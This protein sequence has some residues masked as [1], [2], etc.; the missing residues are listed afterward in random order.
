[1]PPKGRSAEREDDFASPALPGSGAQH[2]GPGS[3]GVSPRAL[4][5]A[6]GGRLRERRAGAEPELPRVTKRKT[7]GTRGGCREP[8]LAGSQR[9]P[10]SDPGWEQKTRA[11]TTGSSVVGAREAN[12]AAG[13]AE[14]A[15]EGAEGRRR[16][17]GRG[18]ARRRRRARGYLGQQCPCSG[19]GRA[20]AGVGAGMAGA[21]GAGT[22]ALGVARRALSSQ[23]NSPSRRGVT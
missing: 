16:G 14:G 2:L 22:A 12:G 6:E 17:P 9:R 23:R 1:M 5:R 15:E 10:G 8:V 20:A 13:Q 7:P 19:G 21:A 3:D 4:R 11:R 18:G